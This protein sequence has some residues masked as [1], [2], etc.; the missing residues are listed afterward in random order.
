[1]R[2]AY[3]CRFAVRTLDTL[4]TRLFLTVRPQGGCAPVAGITSCHGSRTGVLDF[5]GTPRY[6]LR[7]RISTAT[8]PLA[9]RNSRRSNTC[10]A[11]TEYQPFVHRLR[12]L[13]RGLGLG[14]TNPTGTNLPSEPS[15]IRWERFALS[16]RYSYR[17]SHFGT[18]HDPFPDRFIAAERSPTTYCP[19]AVNPQRRYQT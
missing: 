9:L 15:G 5:P 13:D 4:T 16:S 8:P 6:P 14:P 2:P 18:L 10:R 11:V 17:H 3:L 1:M 12:P 19:A 7:R